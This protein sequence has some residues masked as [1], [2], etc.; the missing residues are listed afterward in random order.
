M[1]NT[2]QFLSGGDEDPHWRVVDST[3]EEVKGPGY[4]IVCSPLKHHLANEPQ[5]SQW[6]TVNSD[7]N[8]N[9]L[10]NVM[11]T[12][13]TDVDLTGYDLSTVTVVANILV[14]NGV[15]GIRINGRPIKFKPWI[16]I[17]VDVV[18]RQV[19]ITDGFVDGL[20]QIEF[21]VWN[22]NIVRDV[23]AKNPMAFRVEWQAFGRLLMAKP[24]GFQSYNPGKTD[25]PFRLAKLT[26]VLPHTPHRLHFCGWGGI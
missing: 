11:Y 7:V 21:D 23:Y 16:D 20:N 25:D 22:G 12:F 8:F 13:Q 17:E 2:G 4:A 19:E 6:V 1:H 18:Y 3:S 14:D 26:N 24:G 9:C 5:K 15:T 10:P